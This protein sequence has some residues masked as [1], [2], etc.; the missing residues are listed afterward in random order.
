MELPL[1]Q[2]SQSS[3]GPLWV[4]APLARRIESQRSSAPFRRDPGLIEHEN[5]AAHRYASYFS[6]EVRGLEHLPIDGPVLVVGNHNGVI[7]TPEVLITGLA[8]EDRRGFERPA[9]TLTYDLL[10]AVPLLG[11]FL[12]RMGS[13]PAG[14][15]EAGGQAPPRERSSSTI[16]VGTGRPAVRGWIATPSTL[17][18]GPALCVWRCGP[19]SL[20]SRSSPTEATTS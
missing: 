19:A 6:P 4:F 20:S 18:G 17:A 2:D 10:L 8:I 9:Y 1:N 5:R 11:P 3:H 13:I 12:R 7:Y 15:L 16:R 14:N